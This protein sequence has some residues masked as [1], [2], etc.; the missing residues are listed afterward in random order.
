[1]EDDLVRLLVIQSQ[2][3][4]KMVKRKKR[5]SKQF[6]DFLEHVG[7]ISRIHQLPENRYTRETQ[8]SNEL[9]LSFSTFLTYALPLKVLST[10][11]SITNKPIAHFL[12]YL[13]EVSKQQV[14][15]PPQFGFEL[16][17]LAFQRAVN[18]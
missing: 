3:V 8:N 12:E 15:E 14:S 18:S 4:R 5:K 17:V 6:P 7:T 1:M 10:L 2:R 9:I 13:V 16:F 11:V